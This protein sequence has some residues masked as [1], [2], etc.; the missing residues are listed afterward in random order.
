MPFFCYYSRFVPNVTHAKYA[1]GVS[2]CTQVFKSGLKLTG[3][4]P[5]YTVYN[6]QVWIEGNCGRKQN[7]SA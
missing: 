7:L 2:L 1:A 5:R 3:Y 4:S 6:Q